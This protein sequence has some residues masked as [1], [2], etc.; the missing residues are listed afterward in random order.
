M[1]RCS[2]LSRNS[3]VSLIFLVTA[4]VLS[5]V[6]AMAEDWLQWRGID[7]DGRSPEKGLLK[8]WPEGGPPLAWR[9]GGLGAGYSSLAVVA[10]RIYT[11]GDL[12]D[13]QYALALSEED[14]SLLWKTRVGGIHEDERPGPR[15]TPTHSDGHIYFITTDGDVICLK[16][17]DGS[18][19]WRRSLTKDWNGYL[20]KAMGSYEWRSAE[21]PL[22]DGG[23]VIVTPGHVEA[24][25][26]ALDA[27]TG[28]E[29]WR[30]QGGRIGRLGADGAGYAS[31]VVSE[32]A[33][34]RQYVTLVGRGLIGVEAAT[35][36]LLWSYNKVA[37]DIANIPTPVVRGDYV[38]GSAGYGTGSG[39]VK[40]VKAKA[41][42]GV[43]RFVAEEV[44]FLEANV[45]QNHHGGVILEGDTLYTG[46]GHNKGFPLAVDFLT[47]EVRWGPERNAGADSAAIAFADG[48]IYFR[49]RDGRMI[50][51]EATPEA[52]REHGSFLIPDVKM[53]SWSHPVIANGRLLLREQGDLFSY[54]VRG[55]S[56]RSAAI[57]ATRDARA[58]GTSAA[59]RADA[60]RIAV[61]AVK[62]SGSRGP[63]S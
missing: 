12:E 58:A 3:F 40:I 24:M 17:E 57:G 39:L 28:E 31:P 47:G 42:D 33:G 41:E 8:D 10:G 19:V 52:Y 25:M 59:N 7:R 50:L 14:G 55:Y 1:Q 6:P 32:A 29:I 15:S 51:V 2:F 46:T 26:V 13:G 11:L 61:T 23:K 22:V 4:I 63:T 45:M 21:S 30:T 60:P 35:G 18:E 54:E 43:E 56:S 36:R 62:V 48:R 5:A 9:V 38:F 27:K 16:A 44:Y 20:M 37:S 34:V 49:Y 53:Q